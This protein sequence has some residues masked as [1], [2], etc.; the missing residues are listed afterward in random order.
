MGVHYESVVKISFCKKEKRRGNGQWGE[1]RGG[2]GGRNKNNEKRAVFE[3]RVVFNEENE[4][5]NAVFEQLS[6][7]VAYQG[8][9]YRRQGKSTD[10]WSQHPKADSPELRP[11]VV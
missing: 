5:K 1:R 7:S 8:G 9:P 10:Q 4:C 11:S 2:G 3:N 6:K